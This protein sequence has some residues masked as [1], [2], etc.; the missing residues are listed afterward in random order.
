[1]KY[2]KNLDF[3]RF[4]AVSLVILQ[5]WVLKQEYIVDLGVIGVTV[6]FVLSGFLITKILLKNKAAIENGDYTLFKAYKNF[7]IRRSIRIFPIYYG[8]IVFLWVFNHAIVRENIFWFLTYTSNIKTFLDQSWQGT[9]GP[10]WSLAV[11]EQ[12]YFIW[13]SVILLINKRLLL[14]TLFICVVLGPVFRIISMLFS[15]YF[16]DKVDLRVSSGV[17]VTSNI[18]LFAIG[19]ILAYSIYHSEDILVKFKKYILLMSVLLFLIISQYHNSIIYHTFFVMIIA[20]WSYYIIEFLL[21][22]NK[23]FSQN[24]FQFRPFVYLGKI[25]YGLYLY[26][27]PFFFIFGVLSYTE[28]KLFKSNFLFANYLGSYDLVVLLNISYLILI[29]TLSWYCFEKPINNLKRYF[30]YS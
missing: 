30:S 17:L 21:K 10:L 23:N 26:H 28:F 11:E 25:S 4:V 16:F 19:A 22:E 18:D 20:V 12:F 9:L 1:M 7:Y 15:I 27:G 13:P 8:L 2:Y 3:L 6:F 24:I 14:K 29:C 5:H